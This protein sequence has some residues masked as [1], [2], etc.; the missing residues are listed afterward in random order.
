MEVSRDIEL[1]NISSGLLQRFAE[2]NVELYGK[3][4]DKISH[5]RRVTINGVEY[6][7]KATI[8]TMENYDSIASS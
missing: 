6:V 1:I 7:V 4:K 8:M 3:P 2:V 5:W